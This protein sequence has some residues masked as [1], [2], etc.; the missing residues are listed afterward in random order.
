MSERAKINTFYDY[1][2][3]FMLDKELPTEQK[4]RKPTSYPHIMPNIED[5][6]IYKQHKNRKQFIEE[7]NETVFNRL[8]NRYGDKIEDIIAKTIYL[9]RI[10]IKEEPWKV[11]PPQDSQFWSRIK[12]R[13]LKRSFDVDDREARINNEELLRRI[14]SRYTEEIVSVF[15]VKTFMFARKFLTVFFSRLLNTAAGRKLGR[16]FGTKHR[17]FERLRAEGEIDKIRALFD[18]GTVIV[19]PTHFSNLDSILIGYVMDQ[20]MGLPSFTYGAGLNLY[21]TGYT[22]YFMNRL[23]L[24]RV[25]RRKKNP[26]Y[27]EALKTM[28]KISIKKGTNNLFFPGGTRSR[29][30]RL[31]TKLK[32]GLLGS[33]VEAQRALYQEGK[34]DKVFIVPLILG[35]DVTLEAKFLIEQHLKNEGKEFYISSK[36]NFHSYRSVL[37]FVWNIFSKSSD[38]TLSF[39]KPMDVLGNFVNAEGVSFDNKGNRFSLREYFMSNGEIT[40]DTQREHQYTTI[41]GERL[42]E[43]FH[44]ENIVLAS[45]LVA[46]AAFKILEHF[47]PQLDLFG[48]LRLPNKDY[49]FP[50]DVLERVLDDLQKVIFD[51]YDK[52]NIKISKPIRLNGKELIER[53]VADLGVYHAEQPLKFNKK[54][55]LISQSFKLLY[56]YH[57]RLDNYNLEKGINWSNIDRD[58]IDIEVE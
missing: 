2:Y 36:D 26:I 35:Y 28:C 58:S 34:D 45:H 41:L 55:Q 42:V 39:G 33:V 4:T 7:I 21:N 47:N 54:G 8:R 50:L 11:D 31:E 40:T 29:S 9:E 23:G 1:R 20:I 19:V 52:G 30:G 24:Y 6:P 48:I 14:I 25:D 5:W 43:R 56:Y 22:A 32:L 18:K 3:M 44:K 17:V 10:R 13:L 57:N 16:V 12:S 27:L 49:H 37:N 53:G 38:I 51:L 46:F 15:K